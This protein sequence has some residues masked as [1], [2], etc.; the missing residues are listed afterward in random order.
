[1]ALLKT[2]KLKVEQPIKRVDRLIKALKRSAK[3]SLRGQRSQRVPVEYFKI[4]IFRVKKNVE[5][6]KFGQ[7]DRPE[8]GHFWIIY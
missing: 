6:N 2:F 1:M 8:V 5:L 7:I 4:K 3:L